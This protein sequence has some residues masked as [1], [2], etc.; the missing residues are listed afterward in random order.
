VI[1]IASVLRSSLY[2]ERGAG[3]IPRRRLMASRGRR[4]LP[5]QRERERSRGSGRR[6]GDGERTGAKEIGEKGRARGTVLRQCGGEEFR[7]SD[8]KA[9]GRGGEG[10]DV[11]RRNL[12][13]SVGALQIESENGRG[14]KTRGREKRFDNAR[15]Y[16]GERRGEEKTPLNKLRRCE[17]RVCEG[18]QRWKEGRGNY[19]E[20][21]PLVGVAWAQYVRVLQEGG[22]EQA[23]REGLGFR[24]WR[25]IHYPVIE[26]QRKSGESSSTERRASCMECVW[27][28]VPRHRGEGGGGGG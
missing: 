4:E 8:G 7:V 10:C 27:S 24:V 6:E 12:A 16:G 20:V 14:E 23:V 3:W 11:E 28:Y 2:Y 26:L 18:I 9:F 15:R 25:N 17:E 1:V 5:V 19:K 21:E 13:T 22:L